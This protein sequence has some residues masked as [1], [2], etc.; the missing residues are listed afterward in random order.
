MARKKKEQ[1]VAAVKSPVDKNQILAPSDE[2]KGMAEAIVEMSQLNKFTDVVMT[3]I[4]VFETTYFDIADDGGK[5]LTMKPKTKA[6]QVG[7]S[8]ISVSVTQEQVQEINTKYGIDVKEMIKNVLVNEAAQALLKH[9]VT[10]IKNISNDNYVKEYTKLDKFKTIAYKLFKKEYSKKTKINNV[11][12]LLNLIMRESNK[13]A[14]KSK[15]GYG[16]FAICSTKTAAA[17]QSHTEYVMSKNTTTSAN[18]MIYPIGNIGGIT[19]YVDPYMLW[20]D[21]N[22]YIGRKSKHS[23]PG[24]KTFFKDC[25]I[26]MQEKGLGA[27]KLIME[28]RYAVADIGESS[29]H[30][31]RKIEYKD[32]P[33]KL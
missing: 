6:I 2:L 25:K 7:T 3:D 22:I 30:M 13:I 5:I 20:N 8:Q 28:M 12:D 29:K 31:Y 15:W 10:H 32:N 9:Y 4:P 17:L 14:H 11:R 1:T 24:I 23:E 16:N 27:P 26:T 33:E 19:F 18:G 21:N